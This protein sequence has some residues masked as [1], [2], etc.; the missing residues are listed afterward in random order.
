MRSIKMWR[1]T[2]KISNNGCDPV[3]CPSSPFSEAD[4]REFAALGCVTLE[5]A[6]DDEFYALFTDKGILF[7]HDRRARI[8]HWVVGFV[9]GVLT[10]VVSQLLNNVLTR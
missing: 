6:G 5:P 8:W 7:R 10:T 9:T 2:R 3:Y 4:W 1:Y